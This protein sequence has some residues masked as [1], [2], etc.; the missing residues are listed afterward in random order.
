[1]R[2]SERPTTHGC[3]GLYSRGSTAMG[4]RRQ[5]ISWR[6]VQDH[7]NPGTEDFGCHFLT[8]WTVNPIQ[9]DLCSIAHAQHS[10]RDIL[11]SCWIAKGEL[12]ANGILLGRCQRR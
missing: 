11:S 4:G 1:M 5:G 12:E 3:L 6:A 8:G 2:S 7:G 9:R 10:L